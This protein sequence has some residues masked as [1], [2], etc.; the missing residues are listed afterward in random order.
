[1]RQG[2]DG[3][4]VGAYFRDG[5]HGCGRRE[6]AQQAVQLLAVRLRAGLPLRQR[7]SV[8]HHGALFL[9]QEIVAET[10]E[11]GVGRVHRRTRQAQ[12]QAAAPRHAAQEPAA[13][14]VGEQ[15]DRDFRHGDAR[16]FRHDAMAGARHQTQAATHDDAAAPHQQRFHI[17]MD[18]VVEPVFLGKEGQRLR[19]RHDI[20]LL[21]NGRAQAAH[22][23]ARTKGLVGRRV[24]HHA[25]DG[26]VTGPAY[27]GAIDGAYHVQRQCM[28]RLR[29]VEGDDAQLHAAGTVALFQFHG[30]NQ[31]FSHCATPP[32][33]FPGMLARP[34]SG[35]AY[36]T[37]PGTG[38]A[39]RAEN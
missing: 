31:G 23:A 35:L 36:R 32:D 17:R 16:A 1:M 9:A 21:G 29:R 5:Q 34:L 22:V 6:T 13:P 27:E 30:F 19:V 38:C 18:A 33:V 20:R 37:G 15:A 12:E 7:K 39:H 14:H 10:R 8:E 25:G 3:V 4:E 2:G 11:Q 26:V 28:Q 24:Q